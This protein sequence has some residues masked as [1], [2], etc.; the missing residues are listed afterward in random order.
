[1]RQIIRPRAI[2]SGRIGTGI[3]RRSVDGSSLSPSRD[4]V[5]AHLLSAD[6]DLKP[7]WAIDDQ[8][9]VNLDQFSL[10]L[11]IHTTSCFRGQK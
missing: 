2:Y 3:D 11:S 7:L 4:S 9:A 8:L 10:C 6:L 1:M 5:A